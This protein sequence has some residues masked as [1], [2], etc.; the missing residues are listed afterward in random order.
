MYVHVLGEQNTVVSRRPLRENA[1]EVYPK[2]TSR[3]LRDIKFRFPLKWLGVNARHRAMSSFREK[4]KK[5][6]NWNIFS[7][8]ELVSVESIGP[9]LV[10]IK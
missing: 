7:I 2:G 3:F 6:V 1:Q 5:E 9:A 4:K 10:F 8:R